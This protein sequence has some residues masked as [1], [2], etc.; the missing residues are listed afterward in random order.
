MTRRPFLL[1]QPAQ[2]CATVASSSAARVIRVVAS[3]AMSSSATRLPLKH[4]LVPPGH[5]ATAVIGGTAAVLVAEVTSRQVVP[6]APSGPKRHVNRARRLIHRT[7]IPSIGSHVIC[8]N[9]F[10][11]NIA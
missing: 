9:H 10:N 11:W 3:P 5:G 1:A 6:A 2:D 4:S 8:R 7:S